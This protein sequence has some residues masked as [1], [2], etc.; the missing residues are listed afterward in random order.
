MVGNGF[1]A[2]SGSNCNHTVHCGWSLAIRSNE[3]KQVLRSLTAVSVWRRCW[4]RYCQVFAFCVVNILVRQRAVDGRPAVS[5]LKK[6]AI[7]G[8]MCTWYVFKIIT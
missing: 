7:V 3:N 5:Y 4:D 2:G 8:S 1:G 6:I